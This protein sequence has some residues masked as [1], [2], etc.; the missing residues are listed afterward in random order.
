MQKG[1]MAVILGQNPGAKLNSN[2]LPDKNAATNPYDL[3][4]KE[5]HFVNN[6]LLKY[7]FL[8]KGFAIFKNPLTIM[9]LL[10]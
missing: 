8:K 10:P 4:L 5:N 3:T 1:I 9:I 6:S 2:Y 7:R